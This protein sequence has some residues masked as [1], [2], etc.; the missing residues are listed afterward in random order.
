MSADLPAIS[1]TELIKI[2]EKNG[3]KSGRRTNHG[4]SM[5][6]FV[7]GRNLVTIIPTKDKS[8]PAGTLSAILGSKQ[9][10]IGR[11][12]FLKLYKEF[13]NIP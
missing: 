2:L 11:E 12:G 3:W 1:P 6:K 5:T 8:M 4:I 13:K 7:E 9:T 10:Q